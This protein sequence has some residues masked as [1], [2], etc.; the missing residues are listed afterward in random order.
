VAIDC[1]TVHDGLVPKRAQGEL[2]KR[3]KDTPAPDEDIHQM[4]V[5]L[6]LVL[7]EVIEGL[8]RTWVSSPRRLETSREAPGARQAHRKSF[9]RQWTASVQS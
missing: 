2:L 1:R 5:A 4:G 7:D 3:V 8:R 6:K 9:L